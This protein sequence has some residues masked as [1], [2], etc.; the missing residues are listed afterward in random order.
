MRC[1]S[2][3]VA[4]P[5][6][7]AVA[8]KHADPS[9]F[10]PAASASAAA[11][12]RAHLRTCAAVKISAATTSRPFRPR[13]CPSSYT[14]VSLFHTLN[15]P[16]TFVA[17]PSS[18]EMTPLAGSLVANR[19]PSARSTRLLPRGLILHTGH[20]P[21]SGRLAQPRQKLP[22]LASRTFNGDGGD[23][24]QAS[25]PSILLLPSAV[26]GGHPTLGRYTTISS[27][28]RRYRWW[29]RFLAALV[30]YS[31]WALPF[32]LAFPASWPC[33]AVPNLILD[34][35]FAV[36]I[37]LTFFVAY[38]EKSTCLLIDDPIKIA[39]RYMTRPSFAM[40]VA[41]TMPLQFMYRTFKGQPNGGT[42]LGF[43]NLLRLWRLRRVSDLFARLEKDIRISYFWTR[44]VKLICVTLFT[45]HT[46][47]CI[48]YWM[49]T[50]HREAQADTWIG[51]QLSNFE[52]EGIWVGYIYSMYW[53]VVTLT[54]V[55]YGDLYARNSWEKAF[56]F[57]YMVFNLGFGSYVIGN[58]THLVVL[59]GAT[60]TLMMREAIRDVSWFAR[61]NRLPDRLR[62]Q[63]IAHIQLKFKAV[64]LHQ[65]EVIAELPKAIRTS[66]KQ[67]L[68]QTTL[69]SAYLFKGVSEDVLVQLISKM[70]AEYYPPK[71]DIIIQNEIPT[72]FYIIVSGQ[73][74]L[75]EL[76]ATDM[77][78]EIGMLFNIPQPFKV[79][80]KRLSQVVKI[81]HEHLRG[82]LLSQI[83]EGQKIVSNLLQFL[84]SL[85]PEILE[86]LPF[87]KEILSDMTDEV[88]S[89]AGQLIKAAS[90]L[91]D[92]CKRTYVT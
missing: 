28:D 17:T 19:I 63:M 31:A 75:A 74:L 67:H 65:E 72:C 92:A 62:E 48:Y 13:S 88:S 44:I 47:G 18:R 3:A 38:W 61:T 76:Q 86:E 27:Q 42:F 36:D 35:F 84:R 43:A 25:A 37:T 22:S 34:A 15:R 82:V 55:G 89:D 24:Q 78:G 33:L 40:D 30:V 21:R 49:A 8:H 23:L 5:P 70:R 52:E 20:Q 12:D 79:R 10:A 39:R 14:P 73:V 80:S 9:P 46:A 6:C 68:F 69:E 81:S 91:A 58:M 7:R 54:T 90:I 77:V 45:A 85:K 16:A 71:V 2:V 64:E 11:V 1:S 60:R 41:S 53:S 32:E 83:S 51:S 50:H 29:Q 57:L 66:M 59:Q 4:A 26:E 56:T 87:A